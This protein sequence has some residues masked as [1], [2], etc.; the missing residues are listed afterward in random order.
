MS[1]KDLLTPFI[2]EARKFSSNTDQK[3]ICNLLG[4]VSEAEMWFTHYSSLLKLLHCYLS[5]ALYGK[6]NN[7]QGW[8]T[9]LKSELDELEKHL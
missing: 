9:Q 5:K 7:Q 2:M 1:A 6:L 8:D 3:V 4:K